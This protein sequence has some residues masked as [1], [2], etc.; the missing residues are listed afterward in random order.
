MFAT[1]EELLEKIRLGEGTF[2]EL[3]EVR[4]AGS[5]IR[6]PERN[7]LADE[8]AS[9]AN[10]HGGVLVLGVHDKTREILGIPNQ[11][12]NAVER[13][14]HEICQDS[15]D[16]PIAPI[17]DPMRL[18]AAIGEDVAVIKI[19]VPRG[20]FVHRSPGGFLH[21]VGSAKR[22]M[23]SEYLARLFQQRGQTRIIRFDEQ[24][25]PSAELHD[26]QLDLWERFLTSRSR[27]ER[28][29]FLSKLHMARADDDGT[30]RPTVAGLLM[31]SADPREWL[32]NAYIQAVSYRGVGI[33]VGE[34][35][36]PY[37]LDAAD[38]SGPL[39]FQVVE[40]C[41][42]V[43]KNMKTAAFKDQGRLDRPQFDMTA[44]FEALVNAVAHRDYSIHGSKVRLRLFSDRLELYSPG[45]IPNTM[46]V[47]N[48]A[49]LQATR[50]EIITSLLAKCP[51]PTDKTWLTTDRR[52]MMDRRGEGVC[53][54]M[55][56]SEKLS[57]KF[58]EY[59]LIDESELMLTIWS[60]DI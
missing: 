19:D 59:R 46:T 58:P 37:Q 22:V 16:P 12:F 49:Y 55:E 60:A 44:V 41:Q 33:R 54:I 35:T 50:N 26:L 48:L 7:D 39:D 52:T 43:A 32:P 25:V 40:A 45:S 3:K 14:V 53:L 15:I 42:F 24:I 28:E 21:R 5:K 10:S 11:H 34:S 4:F 18:P 29:D 8:L 2:L 23:S 57:H 51:V 31:A 30:L 36:D 9:F 17:I 13:F 38:I 20:I 27:D 47:E 6:G 56:N 1:R